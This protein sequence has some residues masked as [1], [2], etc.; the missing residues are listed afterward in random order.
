MQKK[1]FVW[2]VLVLGGCHFLVSLLIVPLTLWTGDVLSSG[3][4]KSILMGG[5]H[6]LTKVFYYP[7]LSF[8][9]YP[10]HWF[11]GSWITVPILVNS[12][13]CGFLLACIAFGLWRIRSTR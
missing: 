5:L 1:P 4:L 7:I 13:L 2:L 9:L 12:L 8:A 10:R 11:P 6:F 3:T